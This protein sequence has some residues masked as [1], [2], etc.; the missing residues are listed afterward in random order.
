MC[1]QEKLKMCN[2]P[3]KASGKK[4]VPSSTK[5]SL[6]TAVICSALSEEIVRFSGE[7]YCPVWTTKSRF[8]LLGYMQQ[9]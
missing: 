5:L 6:Y 3:L 9:M 8:D 1:I 7:W 2:F 4:S